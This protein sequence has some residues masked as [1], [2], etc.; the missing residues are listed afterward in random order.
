MK[1]LL[2]IQ[3]EVKQLETMVQDM[4]NSLDCINREIQEIR[5]SNDNMEMDYDMIRML[6]K[7]VPF[8]NHPLAEL[9]D[10]YACKLYIELLLS[11]MQM[12]TNG[13]T[14]KMVYIQWILEESRLDMELEDAYAESLELGKDIYSEIG[15]VL[16]TDFGL[17]FIVDALIVAN[18]IEEANGEA[19][20]YIAQLCVLLGVDASY[21][22]IGVILA[23]IALYQDIKNTK[24][25][26]IEKVLPYIDDFEYCIGKNTIEK[27]F[28]LF[29]YVC[30]K[31]YNDD[32]WGGYSLSWKV[33]QISKVSK[34]DNIAEYRPKQGSTTYVK[35]S[36][37][38]TLF[39]F[40]VEKGY[41]CGS[42]GVISHPS[43][44]GK[45]I[46]Q[47]LTKKYEG[48]NV[49]FEFIDESNRFW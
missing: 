20:E 7:S 34:G 14:E 6:A 46:E 49:T 44:S 28:W 12:D 19:I 4:A 17:F 2:D 31:V 11:V 48:E 45:K 41:S 15:E 29:R 32:L 27:A 47:W 10:G 36:Q 26:D 42:V 37:D 43:D 35:A 1:S 21:M 38:G 9:E 5:T 8:A 23:K 16:R 22:E 24:K 30:V 25:A 13:I 3:K 18:F 39:Q 33:G 40:K